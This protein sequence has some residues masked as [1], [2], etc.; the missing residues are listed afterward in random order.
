MRRAQVAPTL[1]ST[2]HSYLQGEIHALLL[3]HIQVVDM[4]VE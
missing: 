2:T 1:D 4:H 3:H